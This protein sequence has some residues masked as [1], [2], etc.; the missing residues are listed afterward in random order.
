MIL[1]VGLTG[2]IASGKSTVGRH[3][4]SLGAYVIDADHVVKD[5]YQPGARGH[6]ALVERYGDAVLT[7]SGEIDRPALS[8]IALGTPGGAEALNQL[9]HPLV[10]QDAEQR[11]AAVEAEGDDRV[12]VFEA[13]LLLEA[14]GR[15]RYDLVIVVDTDAET[16][17]ARAVRRGLSEEEARLR[18]SRQMER[19]QRLA[20][21]DFVIDSSGPVSQTLE[22]ASEVWSELQSILQER[23][24]K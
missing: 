13:T 14:G 21:A 8:R 22:R 23:R 1:K 24:R 11:I 9:I 7:A 20:G 17:I 6:R 2:G 12:V 18:L 3:L 16:Q 4:A 15:D 10:L 19:Q 5:L